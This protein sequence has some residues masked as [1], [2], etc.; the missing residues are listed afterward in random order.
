MRSSEHAI[1]NGFFRKNMRKIPNRVL[2]M[3]LFALTAGLWGCQDPNRT[4]TNPADRP[5]VYFEDVVH[6]SLLIDLPL[7]DEDGD[8]DPDGVLVRLMLLRPGQSE[9]VAAKGTAVFHLYRRVH[10]EA[11]PFQNQELYTWT[12]SPDDFARAVVRQRFGFIC[13]QM[14]L[15]WG[16]LH[17]RGGGV[18]LQAEFIRPDKKVLRSR[19]ISIAL[20][21]AQKTR[22]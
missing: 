12:I 9:Y 6:A 11:G 10:T 15:Y 16:N 19:P 13:H 3:I 20:P 2:W 22:R 4:T 1:N 18:Y 7:L 8:R 5:P 14:A 17:P 21:E